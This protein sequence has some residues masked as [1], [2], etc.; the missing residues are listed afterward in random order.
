MGGTILDRDKTTRS[1]AEQLSA[2]LLALLDAAAGHIAQRAGLL[3]PLVQRQ[4]ARMVS[5]L[6]EDVIEDARLEEFLF[7][8]TRISLDKVRQPLREFHRNCCFYCE[9][10]IRGPAQPGSR[11]SPPRRFMRPARCIV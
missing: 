2:S 5:R 11:E 4:W 7:G 1:V 6:N 9:A 8:G 10:P 3:R